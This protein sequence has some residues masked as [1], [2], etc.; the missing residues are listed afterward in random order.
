MFLRIVRGKS[1]AQSLLRA[2][3]R[4]V[5][6]L[7]VIQVVGVG[8]LWL[9]DMAAC[10]SGIEKERNNLEKEMTLILKS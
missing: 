10:S 5:K 6:S 4:V 7:N 3:S 2:E 9:D 8:D 1:E